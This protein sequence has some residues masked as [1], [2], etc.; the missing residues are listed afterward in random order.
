MFCG[1][2]FDLPRRLCGDSAFAYL[3]VAPAPGSLIA[4][5]DG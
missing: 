2:I 4:S 3:L 1:L 5:T